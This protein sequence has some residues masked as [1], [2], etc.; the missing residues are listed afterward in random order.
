MMFLRISAKKC[1]LNDIWRAFS[2]FDLF[3]LFEQVADEQLRQWLIATNA[4]YDDDISEDDPR[5]E[6]K[7]RQY[8]TDRHTTR[9]KA[10]AR[11][12]VIIIDRPNQS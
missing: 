9:A 4:R 1:R 12:E 6:A 2:S 10:G 8:E 3:Q 7:Q 11:N 5:Q